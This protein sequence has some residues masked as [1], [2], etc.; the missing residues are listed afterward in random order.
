[1]SDHLAAARP[2]DKTFVLAIKSHYLKADIPNDFVADYVQK[3]AGRLIGFA[4]VDPVRPR[5]AIAELRR[6][7]EQLGMKGITVWPAGQDF[8]PTST[9][10]MRVYSEAAR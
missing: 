6:A 9:V 10:A 3:N 8:H 5:E 2:V 7:H 1:T 4:A